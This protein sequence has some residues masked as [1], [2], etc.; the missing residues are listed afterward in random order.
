MST[1]SRVGERRSPNSTYIAGSSP[2]SEAPGLSAGYNSDRFPQIEP[3]PVITS[4]AVGAC[5]L[6]LVLSQPVAAQDSAAVEPGA[7]VR[8]WLPEMSKPT[9]AEVISWGIDR[10]RL[11]PIETGDTL[12][13]AL[14]ALRRLDVR[15]GPEAQGEAGAA[16]GLFV[17]AIVGSFQFEHRRNTSPGAYQGDVIRAYVFAVVSAGVGWLIGSRMHRYHWQTVPLD[18]T[19]YSAQTSP[20]PLVAR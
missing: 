5:L 6:V 16:F 9:E 8:Y 7:R 3:S 15:R 13:F 2:S 19:A 1:A 12:A 14:S 20:M 17:G 18:A 4:T 10:I 11:R